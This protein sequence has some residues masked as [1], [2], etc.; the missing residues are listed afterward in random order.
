MAVVSGSTETSVKKLAKETT[1]IHAINAVYYYDF[2]IT[3]VD[4]CRI[5]PAKRKDM[6]NDPSP[7]QKQYHTL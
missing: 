4:A 6:S 7:Q 3:I 1:A 2:D 5:C